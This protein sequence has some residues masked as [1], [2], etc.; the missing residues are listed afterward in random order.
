MIIVDRKIPPKIVEPT[1]SLAA[2][3][4]PGPQLPMMSGKTARQV[5]ALV[6][7][8]ARNLLLQASIVAL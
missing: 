2:S 7:M 3:P 5:L 1:A 4:A 6:I 8:M